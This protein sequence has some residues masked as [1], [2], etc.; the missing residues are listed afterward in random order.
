MSADVPPK[1]LLNKI[2]ELASTLSGDLT[3][4]IPTQASQFEPKIWTVGF[5]H[6]R[7]YPE[8]WNMKQLSN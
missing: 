2:L 1:I 8:D 4:S 7:K 6:V 3:F 5:L